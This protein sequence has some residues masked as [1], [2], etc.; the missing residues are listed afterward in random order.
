[1]G[2]EPKC[3]G[4]GTVMKVS[5]QRVNIS[6]ASRIDRIWMGKEKQSRL[7][8]WSR[9]CEVRGKRGTDRMKSSVVVVDPC[10]ES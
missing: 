6:W 9:V 4:A 8:S 5:Q 3:L 1:M 10:L 7:P 2:K